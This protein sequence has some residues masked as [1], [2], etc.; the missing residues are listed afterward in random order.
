MTFPHDCRRPC[1]FDDRIAS[2]VFYFRPDVPGAVRRRDNKLACIDPGVAE[3]SGAAA[4]GF[5]FDRSERMKQAD[6]SC[7]SPCGAAG[8]IARLWAIKPTVALFLAASEP[9]WI[10]GNPICKGPDDVAGRVFKCEGNLYIT[11]PKFDFIVRVERR[12]AGLEEKLGSLRDF[13]DLIDFATF[14][15]GAFRGWRKSRI[16]IFQEQIPRK[17][18]VISQ[19]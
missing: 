8:G 5:P 14:Y 10:Y 4:A 16:A 12:S 6:A 3:P 17:H 1:R 7:R 11:A 13:N 9:L 15:R 19:N 18:S 2:G